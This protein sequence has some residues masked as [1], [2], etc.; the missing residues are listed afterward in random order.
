MTPCH[1]VGIATPK[2]IF[3]RGLWFGPKRP[4]RV[5]IWVHGLGSSMFSKL[6][7][8]EKLVDPKTAVLVFNN[9]GHDKVSRLARADEKKIGK[10]HL[11]GAA[12]EV[13]TDCVDDIQ[14][15][16]N[17]AKRQG[18]KETFLIGHSTGCQK[19]MY[20]ASKK[21]DRAVKGIILLG[22]VSDWS[23]EMKLQGKRKLARAEKTARALLKRGKKHELLP[24]GVWHE[25]LD[26][27]RFL[28]LYTPNSVEEIFTYAQPK[29][30]PKVLRS[31]RVPV[32]VVWAEK[33]EF[34]DRPAGEAVA[35][36]KKHLRKGKTVIIPRT[37]HLFRGAEN[38][39][40][41]TIR[42]WMK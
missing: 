4:K 25:V 36:F 31:V 35:W 26:A 6:S 27:Q 3:L 23:A 28:S 21:K 10:T 19:S 32:L 15:A 11:A 1:V 17:F 24:L 22:P 5:I 16:V 38:R 29:K 8:V 30:N 9:R 2:K 18:A 20:W 33:E 41:L 42:R 14:G 13:F 34:S 37:G 39:V 7:I 12:H 40:A